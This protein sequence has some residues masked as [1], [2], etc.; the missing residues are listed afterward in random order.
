[1]ELAELILDKAKEIEKNEKSKDYIEC[2]MIFHIHKDEGCIDDV[3]SF[4]IH[5]CYKAGKLQPKNVIIEYN[6]T[7]WVKVKKTRKLTEL[8]LIIFR[9]MCRDVL[10]KHGYHLFNDEAIKFNILNKEKVL[11]SDELFVYGEIDNTDLSSNYLWD[12]NDNNELN[13][14]QDMYLRYINL[15]LETIN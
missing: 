3:Y 6:D 1:M 10:N 4:K 12:C 9:Q 13:E 5:K 2:Q 11:F 7:K 8:L 15:C 14:L